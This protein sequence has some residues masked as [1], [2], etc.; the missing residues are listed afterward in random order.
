MLKYLIVFIYAWLYMARS[1]FVL[2]LSC[3][4][5]FR[6]IPIEGNTNKVAINI[7]IQ[8]L[9]RNSCIGPGGAIS[10]IHL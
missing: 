1:R 5:T 8:F 4:K 2:L 9:K 7:P 3:N 6:L 10:Y